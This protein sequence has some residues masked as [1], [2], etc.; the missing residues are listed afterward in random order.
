MLT[1]LRQ[2]LFGTLRRQ[3]IVGVA[4]LHALM[5][6]LF[7]WDLTARQEAMLLDQQIDHATALTNSLAVSSAGWLMARD[8]SGLQ[9][10]VEAQ[11]R[12]P[13]L[14]FAMILDREGKVLAHTDARRLGQY[15]W[16][17]PVRFEASVISHVSGLV[18][19]ARPVMLDDRPVGWVRIGL[20]QQLT[21]ARLAKIT[22]DGIGYALVA[23]VIGS[24]LASAM[25]RRLTRRLYTIQATAD[26]VRAGDTRRRA[27]L[28][29]DG[30]DEAARLAREF[31]AMLDALAE[32]ERHLR[33]NEARFRTLTAIAPVGIFRTDREGACIDVNPTWSK[34]TGLSRETALGQGW[35]RALHPEDRERVFA[36]W[37][38]A[39]RHRVPFQSEYR[40]VTPEGKINWVLGQASAELADQGEVVG[41]VGTLTDITERRQAEDELRMAASVF[42]STQ[43][44]ILITDLAGTILD[45]NQAFTE[46][47]GYTR[48]EALGQNPRLLKSGQHN[49]EFY[50]GLWQVLRKTGSW[51]GEIWNRK[52]N[53]EIYPEWLVI[54]TV[55]DTRG[56]LTHYIGTFSDISL[57]KQQQKQLEHIAHYDALTGI[58]NRLLLA[59]RLRQ[60]LAHTRRSQTILAVGYLDLDGFKAINDRYGHATGDLLLIEIAQRIKNTL[61]DSD[62]VARLGGDEFVFL[63]LGLERPEECVA[64]LNRLLQVIS[65]P[66]CLQHQSMAVSASI[67]VS[68]Y[69]RDDADPDTLLRHADQAMY[70]AKQTGKNRFHIYDPDI[71][72]HSR[73]AP[74][75]LLG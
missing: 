63:L 44:G 2:R 6:S 55:R 25:G 51:G 1:P 16:D 71:G 52:K 18:D 42:A 62:T 22:R 37:D 30:L 41:Y 72:P 45:I 32:N 15:V 69:P 75:F 11:R 61:R 23:I 38:E 58:P 67:G 56:Q 59:D 39:A 33:E 19:V 10:I 47:T 70:Q 14:L 60:A 8:F 73:R 31:D 35:V 57:L 5:M 65:E 27:A 40:F 50:T 13:E 43:E 49:G 53:G 68:L 54:S 20:G 7:V 74:I 12:Y 64:T 24:V 21:H 48:A 66:L 29:D 36:V 3:L 9:E 28:G 4:A 34:I 17:L 46:I 26:A